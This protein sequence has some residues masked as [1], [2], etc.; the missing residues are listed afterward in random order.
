MRIPWA[1]LSSGG[2]VRPR[3]GASAID[4]SAGD[5]STSAEHPRRPR[6]RRAASRCDAH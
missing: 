4:K 5:K 6:F 3:L 2:L 1:V